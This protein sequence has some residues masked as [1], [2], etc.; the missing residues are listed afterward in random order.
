MNYEILS[1]KTSGKLAR[2]ERAIECIKEQIENTNEYDIDRPIYTGEAIIDML[3]V[4]LDVLE[5]K[6]D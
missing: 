4:I 6:N 2:Y 3:N 1:L 5:V